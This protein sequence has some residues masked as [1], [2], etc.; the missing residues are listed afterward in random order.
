MPST[1]RRKM[2][3]LRAEVLEKAR[4]Q[5]LE[6]ALGTRI[7]KADLRHL[8]DVL[9]ANAAKQNP[10]PRISMIGAGGAYAEEQ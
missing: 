6:L 7:G 4:R 3:H 9:D 10:S 5:G 8:R 2:R 1:C